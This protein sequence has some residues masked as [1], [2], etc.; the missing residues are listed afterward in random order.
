MNDAICACGSRIT[1]PYGIPLPIANAISCFIT[2]HS[3]ISFDCC[4]IFLLRLSVKRQ[5]MLQ[6]VR[7]SCF[8]LQKKIAN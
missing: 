6:I 8:C 2:L 3:S 7:F 4:A 5:I 1:F